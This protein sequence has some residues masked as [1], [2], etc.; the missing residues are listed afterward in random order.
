MIVVD[1]N[2][3]A[4]AL[5]AGDHTAAALAVRRRD[6]AWAVPELWRHEFLSILVQYVRARGMAQAEAA[7]LYERAEALLM[8]AEQPV[9]F[10]A[11]LALAVRY[12]LSAYD[13]QYLALARVLGTRCVTGDTELW[14]KVPGLAVSMEAFAGGA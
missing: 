14:Q 3:I 2:V 11:A 10:T 4:Y 6:P 1:A 13:A 12:S 9:D 7:A 5:I 8:A